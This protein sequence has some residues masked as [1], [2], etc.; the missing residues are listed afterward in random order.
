[1]ILRLSPSSSGIACQKLASSA[2]SS[3]THGLLAFVFTSFA[4]QQRPPFLRSSWP[5]RACLRLRAAPGFG[6]HERGTLAPGVRRGHLRCH[7]KASISTS[8]AQ[9]VPL[10]Q[11]LRPNSNSSPVNMVFSSAGLGCVVF[12]R[13]APSAC[14]RHALPHLRPTTRELPQPGFGSPSGPRQSVICSLR[15]RRLRPPSAQAK[16][17]QWHI[18]LQHDATFGPRRTPRPIRRRLQLRPRHW[19]PAKP[20]YGLRPGIIFRLLRPATRRSALV[21]ATRRSAL[22]SSTR[23]HLQPA[24][25]QTSPTF[26]PVSQ[27]SLRPTTHRL[28]S[29]RGEADHAPPSFG[30]R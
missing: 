22:W 3:I 24:T 2:I 10:L 12:A 9:Q 1:M 29:A 26:G 18:S 17:R 30:P 11:R 16:Q 14:G 19:P 25:Q 4:S 7:T 27:R 6:P 13:R 23:C 21:F 8:S 20:A 5:R 15:R 28:A